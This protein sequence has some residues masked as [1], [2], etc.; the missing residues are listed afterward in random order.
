M[1]SIYREIKN[2]LNYIK[3]RLNNN[4]NEW[5]NKWKILIYFK[6]YVLNILYCSINLTVEII[7]YWESFVCVSVCIYIHFFIFKI[8]SI[9][10]HCCIQLLQLLETKC[11]LYFLFL[12][13]PL[14]CYQYFFYK[15]TLLETL[16]KKI[17]FLLLILSVWV[18]AVALLSDQTGPFCRQM[19]K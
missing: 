7:Y 4:V 19:I 16:V 10:L 13:Y 2:K 12:C 1:C 15:Q 9:F 17:L 18:C 6:K 5:I 14:L 8:F 11:Y 3:N